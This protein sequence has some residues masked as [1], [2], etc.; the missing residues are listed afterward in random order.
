MK[1]FKEPRI[2]YSAKN[3]PLTSSYND[4]YVTY[5]TRRSDLIFKLVFLLRAPL[6]TDVPVLLINHPI[7]RLVLTHIRCEH[8]PF[9]VCTRVP[10]LLKTA[11]LSTTQS[12]VII[13][14]LNI[15]VHFLLRILLCS[16]AW[17]S[18]SN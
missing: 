14:S 6:S 4:W 7:A 15:I 3:I 9:V 2:G 16:S 11:V 18:C 10:N 5:E 1:I 12:E 13:F 17:S 8:V